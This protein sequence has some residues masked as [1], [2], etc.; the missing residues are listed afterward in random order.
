MKIPHAFFTLLLVVFAFSA[1]ASE[2]DDQETFKILYGQA[3]YMV[4]VNPSTY[5]GHAPWLDDRTQEN[6]A[7][8]YR[9]DYERLED[10]IWQVYYDQ[11]MTQLFCEAHVLEAEAVGIWTYYY[12]NG[13][14][15]KEFVFEDG[16]WKGNM[17]RWYRTGKIHYEQNMDRTQDVCGHRMEFDSTGKLIRETY[18]LRDVLLR[19]LNYKDG[20]IVRTET[21]NQG[22]HVWRQKNALL[23]N[24]RRPEGMLFRLYVGYFDE[25]LPQKEAK[26][27]K[28][29]PELANLEEVTYKRERGDGTVDVFVG[30]FVDYKR[31]AAISDELRM[32]LFEDVQVMGFV[33]GKPFGERCLGEF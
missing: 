12:S 31:A 6:G 10:G 8:Y 28:R 27:L 9:L 24:G 15:M 23:R 21:F 2:D 5:R 33:D 1:S 26:T 29:Y 20:K 4:E 19:R 3:P 11:E 14:Q 25:G 16:I 18:Y 17:K 13:K 7:I 32:Y 22:Y 30:A